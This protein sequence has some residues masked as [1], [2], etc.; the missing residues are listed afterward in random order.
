MEFFVEVVICHGAPIWGQIGLHLFAPDNK[1]ERTA[2]HFENRYVG[3]WKMCIAATIH[4]IVCSMHLVPVQL[5]RVSPRAC[6]AK[7]KE[8]FK[9]ACLKSLEKVPTKFSGKF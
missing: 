3:A 6:C 7:E 5:D 4:G 1:E 2:K 9:E 8:K